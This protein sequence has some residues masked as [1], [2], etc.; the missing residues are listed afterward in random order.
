MISA[1]RWRARSWSATRRSRPGRCRRG[2]RPHLGP[3]RW[4]SGHRS[5]CG[6][7]RCQV[8]MARVQ[9]AVQPA[10]YAMLPPMRWRWI[11]HRLD[12]EVSTH[13]DDDG[14]AQHVLAAPASEAVSARGVRH[15]QEQGAIAQLGDLGILAEQNP[16]KR[17]LP[18]TSSSTSGQR[19]RTSVTERP[20]ACSAAGPDWVSGAETGRRHS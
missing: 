7:P 5:W 11:H 6:S 1:P 15:R 17:R 12:G 13:H 3:R 16:G 2:S 18:F 4:R 19:R 9:R 10:T 20:P 8:L 14:L